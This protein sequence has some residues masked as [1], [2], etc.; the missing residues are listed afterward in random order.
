[1]KVLDP[2]SLGTD[3]IITSPVFAS[4]VIS[5]KLTDA[6]KILYVTTWSSS[7]G[8]ISPGM[9]ITVA[10]V[11]KSSSTVISP[12]NSNTGASF[13]DKT[14]KIKLREKLLLFSLF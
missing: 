1:M 4:I 7:S 5:T 14:A 11:T 6:G 3:D 9:T 10:G 13:C 2:H 8:G 12:L